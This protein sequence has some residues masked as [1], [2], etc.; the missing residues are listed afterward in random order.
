MKPIAIFQHTHVGEPGAVLTTLGEMGLPWTL[1]PVMDGAPI[2]EDPRAYSGIVL[3][4]GGMGVNDG[5]DWLARE[6]QFVRRACDAGLPVIGHCL[7]GQI[8]ATALGG[9]VERSPRMEIGWQRL[10]YENDPVVEEWLGPVRTEEVFQWHEDLFILPEGAQRLAGNELCPNEA[11]VF[12][13]RH[14]GMQFHLEMTPELVASLAHANRKGYAH[15]L[16]LGNPSTST[17]EDLMA[18]LEARTQAMHAM[19]RAAYARWARGL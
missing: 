18:R 4:G 7:G 16:A 9:H 13:G 3:M 6:I 11:F 2:P 14:L 17:P 12:D 5:L 1:V 19:M 10:R 15:E 8:L